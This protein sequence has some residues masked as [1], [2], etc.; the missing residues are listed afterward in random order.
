VWWLIKPLLL[1]AGECAVVTFRGNWRDL[2]GSFKSGVLE[3]ALA[4]V[5]VAG[6]LTVLGNLTFNL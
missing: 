2:A 6:P 5:F 4:T 3:L 1:T